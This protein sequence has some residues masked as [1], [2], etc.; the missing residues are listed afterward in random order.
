MVLGTVS[1]DR[2]DTGNGED[3]RIDPNATDKVHARD[4]YSNSFEDRYQMR[5][6]DNNTRSGGGKIDQSRTDRY[7]DQMDCNNFKAACKTNGPRKDRY[8]NKSDTNE[9]YPVLNESNIRSRASRDRYDVDNLTNAKTTNN[10][11]DGVGRAF[12]GDDYYVNKHDDL[13]ENG[14][15]ETSMNDRYGMDKYS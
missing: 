14:K 10:N 4:K 1:R 2:Y 9:Y 7:Y 11:Y 3:F 8:S 15:T 13:K 5:R 6:C 12:R